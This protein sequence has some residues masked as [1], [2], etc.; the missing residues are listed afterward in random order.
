MVQSG[1]CGG[2]DTVEVF[3]VSFSSELSSFEIDEYTTFN[4]GFRSTMNNILEYEGFSNIEVTCNKVN[5]SDS[6]P[7][8]VPNTPAP[9]ILNLLDPTGNT[10]CATM[11]E[12][13]CNGNNAMCSWAA[14]NNANCS[15]SGGDVVDITVGIQNQMGTGGTTP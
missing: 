2:G 8:V 12:A 3:S 5:A 4:V 10:G 9:T 14:Y 7:N 13:T 1:T 6:S 11:D 15:C